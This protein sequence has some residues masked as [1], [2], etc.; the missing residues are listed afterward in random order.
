[1][2]QTVFYV[3][4][5]HAYR[6]AANVVVSVVMSLVEVAFPIR[7]ASVQPEAALVRPWAAVPGF[8]ISLALAVSR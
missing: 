4:N 3:V 5:A 2:I 7:P 6:F 8:S 1:M